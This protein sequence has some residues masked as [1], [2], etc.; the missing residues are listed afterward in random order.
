LEDKLDYEIENLIYKEHF[1]FFEEDDK[2]F[3]P[4]MFKINRLN[5]LSKYIETD[6]KFSITDIS[7]YDYGKVILNP[8]YSDFDDYDG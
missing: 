1:E 8:I 3:I 2:I 6:L 7:P 4:I 5:K